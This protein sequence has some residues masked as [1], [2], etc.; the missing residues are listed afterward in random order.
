VSPPDELRPSSGRS[1]RI[2]LD[3]EPGTPWVPL[4]HG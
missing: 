3:V 1:S 4:R 2:L